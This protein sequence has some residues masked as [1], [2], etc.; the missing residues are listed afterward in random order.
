MNKFETLKQ[1]LNLKADPIGVKLIFEHNKNDEI[2]SKFKAASKLERY[3]Q[4][5]KRA[6]KG[7]FLKITKGDFLCVTGEIMLGFKKPVNI[8]LG[9]R[10]DIRGL[11]HVLLFPIS[12]YDKIDVD[13][14]LLIVNP[15]NYSYGLLYCL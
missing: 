11:T 8:E 12:K 3:C 15:R 14:I 6:S 10:L 7:E 13:S 9:M 2:D 5:V 1:M 4:F